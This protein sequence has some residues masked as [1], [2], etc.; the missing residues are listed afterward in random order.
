MHNLINS[1]FIRAVAVIK[2]LDFM[3]VLKWLFDPLTC[4]NPTHVHENK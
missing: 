3:L 1:N 2:E 4:A